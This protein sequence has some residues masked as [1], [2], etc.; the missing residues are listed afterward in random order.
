MANDKIYQL[1]ISLE[2]ITPS[3]W[4]RIQVP[5][6]ISLLELHFILQIAMGWTN[7][8]LHEFQIRGERYGTLY[9]D[10]YVGEKFNEDHKFKLEEVLPPRGECFSY[11]YDFGDGWDHLIEVEEI[12]PL[13]KVLTYPR[14]LGGARACPPEDVGGDW[15]Y[16]E[17]LEAISHPDHPE[18]ELYLNWIGNEFDPEAFNLKKKD[19]ELNNYQL[20]DMLRIHQRHHPKGQ[21]PKLKLYQGVNRWIAGLSTKQHEQLFNLPL[22]RDVVSLLTYLRDHNV[23]GT[24][25]TGNLPLK[26]V[27]DIAALFVDPPVLDTK[28]GDRVYKLRTEFDVWP[29]Y[30]VHALAEVGGLITRGK[31]KKLRLTRKGEQYLDQE[32]PIQVWFLLETWWFYTNWLIAYSARGMGEHLSYDFTY[33]VL[34]AFLSLPVGR[35]LY[36]EKFADA[37]I[38]SGRL[39]WHSENQTYAQDSLRNSIERMILNILEKFNAVELEYRIVDHGRYTTKDLRSFTITELGAGL[40]KALSAGMF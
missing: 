33:L 17:F 25:S 10:E 7:T 23:R 2:D 26:A 12:L 11:R 24:Q 15:G 30:F 9:D 36:F 38:K 13:A 37:L 28:L 27:R 21:G 31:G 39:R 35:A 8:H 22:R 3:I 6:D 20:S 29:M 5:G 14:C 4:R 18:H 19:A 40:L 16:G 34:D 32:P 1:K